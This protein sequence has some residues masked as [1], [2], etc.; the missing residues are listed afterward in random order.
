V[1]EYLV[2]FAAAA[3]KELQDL[4]ADVIERLLPKIRELSGSPRPA[5]CKKLHGYKNRWRV[6]VGNYRIVYA[7]DD[8]KRTV[9]ITRIAHRKE[10]YE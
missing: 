2:T 8:E 9:D 1:T 10:V 5:G 4:P 7:I 3:K 6:R